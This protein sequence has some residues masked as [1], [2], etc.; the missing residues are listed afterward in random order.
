MA[1]A[2]GS[3]E[4][5]KAKAQQLHQ[6]VF[7]DTASDVESVK[8]KEEAI[9]QLSDTYVKLQDAKALTQLL[10]QLRPFFGVIPKAKTAKIVRNIIDQIAKIP[11]STDIQVRHSSEVQQSMRQGQQGLQMHRRATVSGCGADATGDRSS[12]LAN[13]SVCCSSVMSCQQ[14]QQLFMLQQG[15]TAGSSW[16]AL[17]TAQASAVVHSSNSMPLSDDSPAAQPTQQQPSR[18]NYIPCTTA[19]S[20]SAHILLPHQNHTTSAL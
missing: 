19:H 15:A 13:H 11:N 1:A 17:V 9:G 20:A 18:K 10:S 5:L 14:Q 7:A 16:H 8:Q 6:T 2:S 3:T 12:C 4:D